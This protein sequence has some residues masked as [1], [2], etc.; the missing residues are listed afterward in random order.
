M[1]WY[2]VAN[3]ER[4]GPMDQ[5]TLDRLAHQGVISATT[6]VWQEGMGEWRPYSEMHHPPVPDTPQPA[7]SEN[8]VCSQCGQNFAPDQVIKLGGGYVCAACK[9]VATQKLCEGVLENSSTAEEIRKD[10]IQHEGSV[11]AISFIYFLTAATLSLGTLGFLSPKDSLKGVIAVIF[12]GLAVVLVVA[13]IGLRKLKPWARVTS[14]VISGFGLFGC[15]LG[16]YVNAYILYLL[17]SKK[18]ETVF[19][20]EY[21]RFITETPHIKPRISFMLWILIGLG[22]VLLGLVIIWLVAGSHR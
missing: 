1:D 8:I 13:G 9:P 4:K 19:S 12:L 14:F 3:G 17:L 6:L 22:V 5:A 21:R 10:H 16:T 11:K 20:P 2:Y 7:V 18:S 15:G